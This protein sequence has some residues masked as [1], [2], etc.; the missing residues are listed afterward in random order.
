METV[1]VNFKCLYFIGIWHCPLQSVVAL[2]I[3]E[4][5]DSLS[6]QKRIFFC[7]IF[8]YGYNINIILNAIYSYVLVKLHFNHRSTE[9]AAFLVYLNLK[10]I[11]ISKIK[12]IYFQHHLI[13]LHT[14]S[15]EFWNNSHALH[16]T[17]L[18]WHSRSYGGEGYG[19]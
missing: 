6:L 4:H 7:S 2:L 17:L 9:E 13:F 8:V 11:C 12:F 16:V 1:T 18:K 15:S 5:L 14:V 3:L 19:W 10:F